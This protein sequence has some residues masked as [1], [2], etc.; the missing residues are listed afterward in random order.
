MSTADD[1]SATK[2]D[3]VTVAPAP[4]Q[5]GGAPPVAHRAVSGAL[6]IGVGFG[7]MYVLRLVASMIL[8]R[9]LVREVYALMDVAMV[10]IQGLHMFAD[11]GIGISIVQSKRGEDRDFLN[12]AWTL[13]VLRGLVLWAATALIALPVALVY[14]R[15]VLIVLMPAIGATA[16]LDGLSSTSLWT[17]KRHL[18]RGPLVALEVG[19]F[20][21]GQAV[22]IAWVCLVA[23]T[24]WAL[25]AG[26]LT[27]GVVN[28]VVSHFMLRGYR[29]RFR[30][31]RSAVGELLHFGKWIF[32]S[33]MI[34]FLA[35]QADRLIVPKVSG[36]ELMGVYGR[37]L[38]L[39]VI[40][41]SLMSAF[42]VQLVFPIYSRMH[43]EGRD[44][45]VSFGKVQARAAGFAALL[46]SG[47]LAAGP[48]AVHCL[49]GP[50]YHEAG[51]MVQF[52]AVG[53]WF[54]MLEGTLG[55]SL[56][57]LGQARAVMTGNGAR[58]LGVLVFVPLG[59]WLGHWI[60][61]GT[62]YA[63][64]R[65]LAASTAGLTAAPLGDGPLLAAT[66]LAPERPD[67]QGFIGMLLGFIAADAFR[68]LIVLRLARAN[69]LSALAG[70]LVLGLLIL[71]ISPAAA[72]AGGG[73]A[74]FFNAF[75]S[76]PR[77]QD[78]VRF[79]C[80]GALVVLL[81][82]LLFLLWSRGRR[83]RESPPV[84]AAA[85]AP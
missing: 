83:R 66:S 19:C 76:G 65:L 77:A 42:C 70:D 14:E 52:L 41:T 25:V 73:L 18:A 82:G 33:T 72:F 85:A 27:A 26:S 15:P 48:A 67:Y 44:I 13:Q 74:D 2:A 7:L 35:F 32:F 8:T 37:A 45:R 51:W 36:F 4:E 80:Q 16:A 5:A 23:P 31:D 38:S 78:V 22:T 54:Q 9:L 21:L 28:T 40:A 20:V 53:A 55:A 62:D 63:D 12:T 6:W 64:P 10:F 39:A 3:D 71:V 50:L 60:P 81:W 84:D 17:L 58:L 61:L 49:Y 68:Y 57:A 79:L 59:Y 56:L 47:M 11:V 30:W 69:G 29:N 1:L 75:V 24:V 46:V 34:T 43:Q